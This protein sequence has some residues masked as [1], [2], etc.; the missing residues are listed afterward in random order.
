MIFETSGDPKSSG[1]DNH[2]NTIL[3][4]FLSRDPYLIPYKKTIQR[5]LLKTMET[6]SRL[7]QGKRSLADFAAGHEYF[8]LHF[9]N[10][11]WAFREWAPNATRIYL[12]GDMTNWKK[13]L[14]CTESPKRVIGKFVYPKTN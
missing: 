11:E 7:T 4:R 14:P 6:E 8:G 9:L 5:R 3:K 10:G 13:T 12:I 2:I 1:Q